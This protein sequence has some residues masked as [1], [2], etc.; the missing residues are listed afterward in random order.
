MLSF[1]ILHVAARSFTTYS[2]NKVMTN[3]LPQVLSFSESILSAESHSCNLSSCWLHICLFRIFTAVNGDNVT[4]D[5]CSHH[6]TTIFCLTKVYENL[7]SRGSSLGV[8]VPPTSKH[9]C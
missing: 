6:L 5:E 7:G 8:P 9:A 1:L 4:T 3:N 2:H